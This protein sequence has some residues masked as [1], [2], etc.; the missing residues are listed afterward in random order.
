MCGIAGWLGHSSPP[1][2]PRMIHT[3][4]H[5]GPDE[6]GIWVDDEVGLGVARLSIVDVAH[7]H[8]PV[9]SLD[10]SVVAVCNG[11]IYNH[12][13]LREYLI[14]QGVVFESHSD[15]EVIPHLYELF[16]LDFVQHLRGMFAIALWD[17]SRQRLVLARDRSGKKPLWYVHESGRFVFGSEY[18]AIKASGWGAPVNFAALDHLMAYGYVPVGEGALQGLKSVN[19]GHVLTLEGGTLTN[20]QYWSWKAS[21]PDHEGGRQEEDLEETLK[22]AVRI[23]IPNERPFGTFLS[24][25]IDSALV[26]ALAMEAY[27]QPIRTFT[28]GFDSPGFDESTHARRVADYLGTHHTVIIADPDPA[29]FL[30]Y[31][32]RSFDQPLADSS[33]VPTLLVSALASEHVTVALSGDGGDEVFAGYRRYVAVPSLQRLNP[34]LRFAPFQSEALANALRQRGH[35]SAARI[36]GQMRFAPDLG[37]RYS[38]VMQLVPPLLRGELWTK[39]ILG[40]FEPMSAEG[41]FLANW[42]A[43]D[44]ATPISHMQAMDFRSYLPG[45]L[46]VKV[47]IASMAHSLEVRSPLLDQEVV[48]L[49]SRISPQRLIHGRT[50][51][52]VLRQIL[53]KRMP[54]ELFER[55]KMGFGIPRAE[56]LRGSWRAVVRDVL[57]SPTTRERGWF[58]VGRMEALLAEHDRGIDRDNVIWPL[59]IIEMWARE[60]V[61]SPA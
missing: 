27:G 4:D 51:K 23:R 30:P 44:E 49:A 29:E 7:G 20:R 6:T 36:A 22:E 9:F 45:D 11:E 24:G 43:I 13:Q 61:D 12:H 50:T 5:R 14:D 41:S 54:L 47:D 53:A 52:R 55:P 37:T 8:Q 17:R 58:D 31:L 46:L 56:W 28:V 19:P 26:T 33:A 48:A 2:L 15:V 21:P 32:A 35:R 59:L 25:G 10:R 40:Q 38:N 42:N 60:W 18:R 16:G 1:N 3:L 57:V 34:L 39:E